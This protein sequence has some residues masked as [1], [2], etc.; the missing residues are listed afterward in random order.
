M[1]Y[2]SQLASAFACISYETIKHHKEDLLYELPRCIDA[3][4][5]GMS[6]ALTTRTTG[7]DSL[8]RFMGCL[9]DDVEHTYENAINKGLSTLG[10][11]WLFYF[12]VDDAGELFITI[13]SD[14]E[15]NFSLKNNLECR[16]IKYE[17]IE[18]LL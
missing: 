3:L 4:K 16:G 11:E 14:K 18:G 6:Y 2:L 8:D 9:D 17:Y 1:K 5:N 10:I 7:A 12:S 15:M 13:R